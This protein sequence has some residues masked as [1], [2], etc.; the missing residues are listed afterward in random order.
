MSVDCKGLDMRGL[1]C[2]SLEDEAS[3]SVTVIIVGP[4]VTCM[5]KRDNKWWNHRFC[6]LHF[7]A[8]SSFFCLSWKACQSCIAI[9]N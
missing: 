6:S 9:I 5:P 4:G 1:S 2:E 7:N 3:F 8:S